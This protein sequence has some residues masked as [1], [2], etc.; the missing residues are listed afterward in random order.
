MAGESSGESSPRSANSKAS[1]GH[2]LLDGAIEW[3]PPRIAGTMLDRLESKRSWPEAVA[4]VGDTIGATLGASSWRGWIL[5]FG[6]NL[7]K[8]VG[9]EAVAAPHDGSWWTAWHDWLGRQGSARPVP[10]REIPPGRSLAPAPGTYV[11][12]RYDD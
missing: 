10:A 6:S 8:P 1:N 4:L 2:R 5:D 11:H 12:V 3:L 9:W 7:M